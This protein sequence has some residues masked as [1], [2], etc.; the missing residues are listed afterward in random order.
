MNEVRRRPGR[1]AAAERRKG[2][3]TVLQHFIA[4]EDFQLLP[5]EIQLSILTLNPSLRVSIES[6]ISLGR[7]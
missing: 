5:R 6:W 2:A 7:S 4:T 3:R 1:R